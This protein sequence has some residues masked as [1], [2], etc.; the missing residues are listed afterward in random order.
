ML[1]TLLASLRLLN[2][3][4]N[5]EVHVP[6]LKGRSFLSFLSMALGQIILLTIFATVVALL[7]LR[8]SSSVLAGERTKMVLVLMPDRMPSISKT[9]ASAP[10]SV[11]NLTRAALAVLA[12]GCD[13]NGRTSSLGVACTAHG[14]ASKR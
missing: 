14:M 6:V 2:G 7:C 8:A 13:P 4:V 9:V 12:R 11:P 10:G 5:C 1:A 3:R